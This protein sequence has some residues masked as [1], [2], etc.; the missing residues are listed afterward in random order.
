MKKMVEMEGIEDL[1]RA[2]GLL[3]LVRQD[4][5][6]PDKGGGHENADQGM[7]EVIV[8]MSI[9]RPGRIRRGMNLSLMESYFRLAT[10]SRKSSLWFH[11]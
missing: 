3:W 5:E 4:C 10:C 2:L 7:A 1:P 9:I 11:W 8:V 6:F